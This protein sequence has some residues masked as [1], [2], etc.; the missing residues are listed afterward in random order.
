MNEELEKAR[1]AAIMNRVSKYAICYGLPLILGIM[2]GRAE[3]DFFSGLVCFFFP[4]LFLSYFWAHFAK[5]HAL[6]QYRATYKKVLIESAL[7]GASLYEDMEFA[8]DAGVKPQIV[9]NSGLL[10]VNSFYSDC[11]LSGVYEGVEFFQADIRNVSSSQSTGTSVDYDGTFIAFPTTLPNLPQTNIYHKDV[12]ISFLL[13]GK[14]YKT[15]HVDFNSQFRV[16]S[17]QHDKAKEL[18]T[19]EFVNKLL[20]VQSRTNRKMLMTITNGWVYAFFP[21]KKSVLKPKLFAKYDESMNAEIL[22]ELSLAQELIREL[23]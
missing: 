16:N 21:N 3:E 4:S 8:Y 7:R 12:D 10:N 1:R 9:F 11:Y 13:P 15:A 22:K 2:Y 6:A 17:N 20:G 23:R 19:A 14:A 18:L 5:N